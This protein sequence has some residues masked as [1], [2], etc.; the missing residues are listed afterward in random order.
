MVA[1]R[2]RVVAEGRWFISEGA[3]GD[4][5]LETMSHRV[6]LC[7]GSE[8]Q[9]VFVARGGRALVGYVLLRPPGWRRTRHVVKL[10]IMVDRVHR[11]QGVGSALLEAAIAWAERSPVV[12]KI[13]LAVFADNERAIRLYRR[14]GFEEEGRR[15]REYKLEDGTYRDDLLLYRFVGSASQSAK[16]A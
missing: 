11:G 13:G 12:E 7:Q 8:Q 3:E 4:V 10:E 14:F 6:A 15:V 16:K 9:A 5:D 1:L 2:R